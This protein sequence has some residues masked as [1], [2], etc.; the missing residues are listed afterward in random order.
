MAG[1]MRAK[2]YCLLSTVLDGRVG[3]AALLSFRS[4][5]RGRKEELKEEV[6][7]GNGTTLALLRGLRNRQ[8][9]L[10]CEAGS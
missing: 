3:E 9:R 1:K 10:E 6:C 7:R 5:L 8:T 2:I 4:S